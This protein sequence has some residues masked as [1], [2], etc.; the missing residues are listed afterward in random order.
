MKFNLLVGDTV[1][2]VGGDYT[3]EGVVV[4]R[5]YKV[6]GLVRFVVEDFRGLLFI[7]NESSLELVIPACDKD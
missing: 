1:R 6:S 5:F 2:K 3:Y 7:F 4:A